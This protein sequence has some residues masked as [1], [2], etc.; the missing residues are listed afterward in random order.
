[1]FDGIYDTI[2]TQKKNILKKFKNIRK[3]I[4]IIFHLSTC[5]WKGKNILLEEIKYSLLN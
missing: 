2:K 4:F 5:N 1:M 3:D